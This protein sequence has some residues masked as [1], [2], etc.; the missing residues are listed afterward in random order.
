MSSYE[1]DAE[2]L[3][4]IQFWKDEAEFYKNELEIAHNECYE[5]Y[6][7]TVEMRTMLENIV[8]LNDIGASLRQL[9]LAAATRIVRP[10]KRLGLKSRKRNG[11]FGPPLNAIKRR[12]RSAV[13]R[14]SL[15]C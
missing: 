11:S 12:A 6:N 2:A 13:R 15:H 5:L 10:T 8:Y 14:S 7:Q 1:F 4:E 9:G 3:E